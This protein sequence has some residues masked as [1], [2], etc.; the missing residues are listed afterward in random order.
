MPLAGIPVAAAVVIGLTIAIATNSVWALNFFHVAGG[1][2]WTALDLFLG[3]V[4]GP[5]IG[6]MSPQARAEFSARFMPK[7]LLLMPTLVTMTLASGFQLARHFAFL[8]PSYPRHGWI[9]ASF[10]VVGVMATVALGFL[11]PA[12]V[13]VLYEMRKPQPNFE[14]IGRLMKRFVYAAGLLG[15]MQ[16]ATLLIMTRLPT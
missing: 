8:D 4:L 12:N 5:I 14:L 11:E 13:A 15:A 2:A 1:G 7:M 16:V 10:I 9:V 3:F 6:G